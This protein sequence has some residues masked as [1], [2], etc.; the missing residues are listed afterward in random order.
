MPHD[1]DTTRKP[2]GT[3]RW[4]LL[5]LLWLQYV[6]FGMVTR[7]ISPLV[8]P[9]VNDLHLSYGQMGFILGS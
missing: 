9:V 8:T 4:L 7:A 2:L 3:Y 5:F 1:E 6:A